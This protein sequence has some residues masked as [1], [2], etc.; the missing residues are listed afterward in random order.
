VLAI[1]EWVGLVPVDALV[2]ARPIITTDHP[3]HSPE[4]DYLVPGE[5]SVVAGHT[6]I[7][8]AHALVSTLTA[9]DRLADM[10]AAARRA[11]YRYTLDGMVD[12][13]VEGVLGWRDLRRAGLTTGTRPLG[14]AANLVKH[15]PRENRLLA[16]LMTCH[17]RREETVR[18]LGALRVQDLPNAE[19]SVYMTDDGSTDGTAAAISAVDMPIRLIAGSGDLY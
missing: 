12:S 14:S 2:S 19:L 3:S 11:S 5:T 7:D 17:N 9:T 6:A 10:Q 18:C 15:A 8:Y 4:Y 13:F 16:V 1:P